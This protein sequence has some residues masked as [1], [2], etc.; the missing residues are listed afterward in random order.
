LLSVADPGLPS[1]RRVLVVGDLALSRG[2]IRMVLSRLGYEVSC[3]GSARECG[4]ALRHGGYALALIALQLD[5]LPGLTLARR[6]RAGVQPLATMP[7]LL[8][9][10]AWDQEGI[11]R[12]AAEAGLQGFLAKPLSIE[13]LVATVRRLTSRHAPGDQPAVIAPAPLPAAPMALDRLDSFT[14]GD[15]DVEAELGTLYLT[16]AGR[17]LAEMRAALAAGRDWTDSAHALKGASA[18]IGA[19]LVARLAAEAEAAAPAGPLL[20]QLDLALAGVQGFLAERRARAGL[21]PPEA[22]RA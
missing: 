14:A 15:P 12:A 16:T 19:A 2:L 22:V 4:L 6:L 5:D 20:D 3:V 17:Y 13:R 18:N 8:F 1:G 21:M 9:G 7:I 10:I 11:V